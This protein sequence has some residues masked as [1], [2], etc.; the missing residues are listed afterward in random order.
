MA[1]CLCGIILALAFT[2][3]IGSQTTW[4]YDPWLDYNDDGKIDAK[5]IGITCRAFGTKGDPV[6]PVM[7][8][9]Q[10]CE[11]NFSNTIPNGQYWTVEVSTIGFRTLTISISA[12]TGLYQP[13]KTI[14]VYTGFERGVHS[15]WIEDFD[16]T[17]KGLPEYVISPPGKANDLTRTYTVTGSKF[18]ICISNPD[19][20]PYISI[21]AQIS[22]YIT[23]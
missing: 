19:A 8:T 2:P 20:S 18:W 7:V 5:D 23:A 4:Q 16:M 14:H 13:S 3:L 21:S 9:Y 1:L 17:A 6:K 22:I 15:N 12:Y 10:T 11:Y